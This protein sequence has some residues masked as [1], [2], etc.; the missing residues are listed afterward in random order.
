MFLGAVYAPTQALRLHAFVVCWL[1]MHT[2][3]SCMWVP[4][5]LTTF[6]WFHACWLFAGNDMLGT[7]TVQAIV[8]ALPHARMQ[9]LDI[10]GALPASLC[11]F[12]RSCVTAHPST[13]SGCRGV[14]CL[15]IRTQFRMHVVAWLYSCCLSKKA[16]GCCWCWLA[17]LWRV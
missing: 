8:D 7:D 16:W 10:R 6:A 4:T 3:W 9:R 12:A 2:S 13:P 15:A 17:C 11:L 1:L 5:L 14:L